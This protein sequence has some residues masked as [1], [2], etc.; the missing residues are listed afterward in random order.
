MRFLNE[1][2]YFSQS[3]TLAALV[4]GS[5]TRH[6]TRDSINFEWRGDQSAESLG[7]M[8]AIHGREVR[9]RKGDDRHIAHPP[10]GETGLDGHE[11]T[12]DRLLVSWNSKGYFWEK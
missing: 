2:K 1:K 9:W 4:G 7:S 11:R 8:P 5:P 10:R 6:F 12:L 3:A